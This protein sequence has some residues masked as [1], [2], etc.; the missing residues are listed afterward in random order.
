MSNLIYVFNIEKIVLYET[1]LNSVSINT[2]GR[3]FII[4]CGEQLHTQTLPLQVK[5]IF[6]QRVTHFLKSKYNYLYE[7]INIDIKHE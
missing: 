1:V 3:H 6:E 4:A 2:R 5:A 7:S